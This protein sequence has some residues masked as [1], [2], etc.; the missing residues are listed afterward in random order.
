VL[1][2]TWRDDIKVRVAPFD[3]FELELAGLWA[4]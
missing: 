4:K 1:L 3:A 2:G